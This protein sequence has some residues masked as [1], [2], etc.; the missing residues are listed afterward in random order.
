MK[1]VEMRNVSR[2]ASIA[3]SIVMLQVSCPARSHSGAVIRNIPFTAAVVTMQA[4]QY[5]LEW[6]AEGVQSVKIYAG[7]NPLQIGTERLVASGKGDDV[8]TVAGLPPKTRWYFK[9]VPDSGHSLVLAN[10]SL[11]LPS[12]SN[13]RDVGGYRTEDGK[14]VRVGVA[15]RSNGLGTLTAPDYEKLKDLGL[16]LVCDLR[17]EEERVKLPDPELPGTRRLAAD[18]SADSSHRIANLLPL[19]K[20]GDDAGVDEFIK[21]AYRDFVNLPG[22]R[23]AYHDLF[24]RLADPD[25]LPTVFHCTAGKDRTG[26]AQAIL[27]TILRVPREAIL[28]DYRL[29]DQFMSPNAI[30]QIRRSFPGVDEAMSQALLSADPA[31][32]E[33]SFREVDQRFGSFDGYLKHG[34]GIDRHTIAAIRANFLAD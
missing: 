2:I 15:Y 10:R 13:F 9:L 25:S 18:V 28:Q 8:V 29:T 11:N 34:L 23:K 21:G 17:L 6:H 12:A 16:H 3:A 1:E 26:W 31:F 7:T 14:W 33:T 32:L 20:S 24:E 19:T 5:T 22:A 27:L 4:L 30:Q